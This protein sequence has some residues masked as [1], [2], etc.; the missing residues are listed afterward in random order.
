MENSPEITTNN[1]NAAV[2]M[3]SIYNTFG[4]TQLIK[5]PNRVTGFS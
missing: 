3:A 4:L 2:H 5:D 1:F